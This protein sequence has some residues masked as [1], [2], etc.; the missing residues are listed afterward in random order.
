VIGNDIVDLRQ[1]R[2]ESNW[3][4]PRYLSK[5]FSE[6]EREWIA[7]SRIPDMLVWMFWSSKEAVYKQWVAGQ[8]Q[9]VFIPKKIVVKSWRKTEKENYHSQLIIGDLA[10][11][12]Q[13]KVTE[14]YIHSW[15]VP[16]PASTIRKQVF[17]IQALSSSSAVREKLTQYLAS[18]Y[19]YLAEELKVQTDELG[20]PFVLHKDQ[21]LPLSLSLS[22]HGGYGAFILNT[23]AV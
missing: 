20:K 2:R 17:A 19:G 9:R 8:E 13:S 14:K 10:Y 4:R 6:Q 5:L 18:R 3:Q 15:T 23:Q 7:R 12:V 21:P 1:A 22:H 16:E 11:A